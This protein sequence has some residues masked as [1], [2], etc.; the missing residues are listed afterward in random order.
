MNNSNKKI[1]LF[2]TDTPYAGGAENQMYLLA[3]FLDKEKYEVKLICSNYK[4]LDDWA[5]RF[6]S[7]GIEVIKL[8]VFHKK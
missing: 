5:S 1:V 4:S 3:K 7:E 8:N 2:Y 6:E